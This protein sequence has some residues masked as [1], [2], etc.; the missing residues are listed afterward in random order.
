MRVNEGIRVEDSRS[1]CLCGREGDVLY[2]GLRDRLFGAPG[3]WAL[4]RCP[5][6]RCGLVWLDPRPVP[7]DLGR[8]YAEYFSHAVEERS[9]RLDRVKDLVKYAVL[10]AHMGYEGGA[11]SALHRAIG[12]ALALV[13]PVRE[14]VEL[15][16][17]DPPGP[18]SGRSVQQADGGVPQRHLRRSICCVEYDRSV[19]IEPH[20]IGT[21][22]LLVQFRAPRSYGFGRLLGSQ[23][24]GTA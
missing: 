19:E 13:G 17:N 5:D 8:L 23:A 3:T 15:S 11:R 20:G 10:A 7:A 16:V 4:W 6:Q 14:V 12:K 1:W 18:G 22:S 9:R 21:P 2:Q 24:L